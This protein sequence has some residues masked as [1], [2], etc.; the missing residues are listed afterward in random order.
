[1]LLSN[2]PLRSRSLPGTL[3]PLLSLSVP[4]LW[5]CPF[6]NHSQSTRHRAALAAVLEHVASLLKSLAHTQCSQLALALS[7]VS[8]ATLSTIQTLQI[9]QV[10]LAHGKHW[11]R[12]I[13]IPGNH[14]RQAPDNKYCSDSLLELECLRYLLHLG[15]WFHVFDSPLSHHVSQSIIRGGPNAFDAVQR[16]LL[17][18]PALIINT[19]T[20]HG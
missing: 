3:Q 19:S 18:T 5:G 7:L 9:R 2:F 11:K 16:A 15:A 12:G 4:Y 13:H 6:L 20:I 1:M 17:E 8:L 14:L 10:R